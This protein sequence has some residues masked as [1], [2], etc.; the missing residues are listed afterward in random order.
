MTPL[1]SICLRSYLHGPLLDVPPTLRR[2]DILVLLER[3]L[4]DNTDFPKPRLRPTHRHWLYA[5]VPDIALGYL[6][7]HSL[8]TH[9]V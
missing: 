4:V 9:T 3:L 2:A 7:S 6:S 1:A 8:G 5:F